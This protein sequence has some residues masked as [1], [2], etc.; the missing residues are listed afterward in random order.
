MAKRRTSKAPSQRQL[1]VGEVIRHALAEI[2]LRTDIRD[3]DLA[4]VVLTVSEV[5]VSP[6]GRQATAFV[7]PLGGLNQDVV[8]EA[9]TRHAKFLRGE[10][11]R[12]VDLKYTPSLSFELDTSFD[13]SERIEEVLRSPDV[14]R[15]LDGD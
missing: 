8:I 4:G 10:L 1:R 15:D 5:R 7:M 12:A 9:L 11:A 3:G 13:R 2:F 14:A 6:D